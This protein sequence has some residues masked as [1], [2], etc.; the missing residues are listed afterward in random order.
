METFLRYSIQATPI[1]LRIRALTVT[2]IVDTA[3]FCFD[4]TTAV[5]EVG[6]EP[7]ADFEASLYEACGS[8]TVTFTNQSTSARLPIAY[9]WQFGNGDSSSLVNPTVTYPAPGEYDVRLIVVNSYGCSDT[10]IQRITIF[11]QAE[12]LFAASPDQGCQ[13]LNVQFTDLSTNAT[14]WRWDLGDGTQSDLQNPFHIYSQ[15]GSYTVSLIASY[16]GKCADTITFPDLITVNRSPVANFTYTDS[17]QQVNGQNDGTVVFSN[18]SF[19]ADVY[20]WDLGDGTTTDEVNP[21]HQYLT[22][23]VFTVTLIASTFSGCSD[24]MTVEISPMSFGDLHIP[25]ALA[26][27]AGTQPTDEF[28]IFLPKGIGL[29]EYHI[30]IYTIWGDLVWE[31]TALENGAA[32][33]VVGWPDQWT[34]CQF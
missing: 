26:P 33:G 10:T 3:G 11:P 14:Q 32:I 34:S 18:A 7:V 28:T 23:E 21:I 15:I 13:P 1:L 2:L 6:S 24:T 27:F 19:F 17:S 31:S 4:S 5:I 16:D 20:A 22:N 30:A 12:A 8:A 9:A 25:N 29:K